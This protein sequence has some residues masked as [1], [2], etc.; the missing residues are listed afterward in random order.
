M[1]VAVAFLAGASV[2]YADGYEEGENDEG[3]YALAGDIQEVKRPLSEV[4]AELQKL[5]EAVAYRPVQG[6]LYSLAEKN[7]EALGQIL[8][9]VRQIGTE[10]QAQ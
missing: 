4:L 8:D 3:E 6:T 2:V 1:L 5:N 10:L 7:N 9:A